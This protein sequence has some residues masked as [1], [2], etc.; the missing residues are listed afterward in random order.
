MFIIYLDE[1]MYMYSIRVNLIIVT[2]LLM[3]LD[4]LKYMACTAQIY[5]T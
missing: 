4:L 1:N 2:L 3:C 5:H